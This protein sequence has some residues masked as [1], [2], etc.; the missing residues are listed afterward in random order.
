[1]SLTTQYSGQSYLCYVLQRN[2][3]N[4]WKLILIC[5]DTRNKIHCTVNMYKEYFMTYNFNIDIKYI[6]EEYFYIIIALV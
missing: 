2:I 4:Q 3:L 6:N 5:I 1:M